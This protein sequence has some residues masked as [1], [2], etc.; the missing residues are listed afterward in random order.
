MVLKKFLLFL[1]NLEMKKGSLGVI[2]VLVAVLSACCVSGVVVN[3]CGE[4]SE[5]NEVYKLS[6]IILH[7]GSRNCLRITAGNVTLDCQNNSILTSSNSEVAGI[8]SEFPRTKIKNCVVEGFRGYGIYVESSD[9]SMISGC[10]VEKNRVGVYSEGNNTRIAYNSVRFNERGTVVRGRHNLVSNNHFCYNTMEDVNCTSK[11][12]FENNHCDSGSVCGE[13]CFPCTHD[14][15]ELYECGELNKSGS[16]YSLM[17]DLNVSVPRT[18]FEITAENVT[19][20]CGGHYVNYD[21]DL[22]DN[23]DFLITSESSS[24]VVKNCNFEGNLVDLRYTGNVINLSGSYSSV[25]RNRF[26]AVK[27]AFYSDYCYGCNVSEN[28]FRNLG[29]NAIEVVDSKKSFIEDNKIVVSSNAIKILGGDNT[30]VN[31]NYAEGSRINSLVVVNDFAR[32]GGNEILNAGGVGLLVS[33]SEGSYLVNNKVENYK[34]GLS[35]ENSTGL[36]VKNNSVYSGDFGI[37]VVGCDGLKILSNDVGGSS[38][39]FWKDSEGVLDVEGNVFCGN[40]FDVSCSSD[41]VFVDNQ[42]NSYSVCGGECVT[43]G[44]KKMSW[45]V[46]IKKFFA[47]LF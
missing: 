1:N 36:L 30:R 17:T 6:S 25:I 23:E 41:N 28:D 5:E 47:D 19:L 11:Q 35:L 44:L 16:V 9:G 43:C 4:L 31:N 27:T 2:L 34:V 32:V 46:K 13:P 22:V 8:Y 38:F 14:D 37:Y 29:G 7:F 45:W 21:L 20:D 3:G 18:C 12:M 40:T 10:S 15:L 24:T 39:G 26:N 33:S 42:C